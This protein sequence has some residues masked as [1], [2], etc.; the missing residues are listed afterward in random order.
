MSTYGVELGAA[1][2]EIRE[3]AAKIRKNA[4]LKE[5]YNDVY[6]RIVAEIP[7]DVYPRLLELGSGGGFFRVGCCGR[8]THSVHEDVDETLAA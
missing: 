5:I 2:E 4:L 8:R 1:G 3:D 7:V 6:S